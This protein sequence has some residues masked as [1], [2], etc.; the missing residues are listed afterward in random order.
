M[1]VGA[2]VLCST[3]L[4]LM[5]ALLAKSFVRLMSVD[6]GFQTEHVLTFRA[7]LPSGEYQKDEQRNRFYD[8]AL[9]RLSRMPGVESVGFSS[10]P[11]L[12][13]E[14]WVDLLN[15]RPGSKQAQLQDRIEANVRWA[16]PDFLPSIGMHLLAGRLL[17]D[18]DRGKKV[19]LLS[20]SA[21]RKLW[22]GQDAVGRTFE[23][24]DQ[25]YTV[26][27][28]IVDARSED[29]SASPIA[30]V[31]YPYWLGPPVSSFF[32]V[33]TSRDPVSVGGSFRLAL[34][35][36]E[37]EVAIS[38]LETMDEVVNGSV[39]E[40]RFQFNLLLAFA[41]VALLLAALGLYGVLSYS[42][43]E[44]TR[45]MGLRIALGASREALYL[46]VF[47]Q[48]AAPVIAGVVGGLAGAWLSGRL[49]TSLL[50]QVNPYD[51]PSAVM[52]IAVLAVTVV[53][54]CY[55]P[56]KRAAHVEPMQALRME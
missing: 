16:S 19:A 51:L 29:L 14:S 45:E 28:V 21:A 52:V 49:I 47:R 15:P 32:A 11:L 37:P 43:A 22:P 25:Q 10:V 5:A 3:A 56:A 31:Y 12:N 13:G 48:A 50:F 4:L 24:N 23:D 55:L 33:R 36:L 44:R 18:Q 46:L 30:V 53:A 9:E 40:Q 41:A 1:L 42:V 38:H 54:A 39:A 27:G 17:G 26:V 7:N 6:R 35:Q 8:E 2:E 34:T 20:S